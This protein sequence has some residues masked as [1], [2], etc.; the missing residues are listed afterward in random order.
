MFFRGQLILMCQFIESLYGCAYMSAYLCE[1]L[2]VY[3]KGLE[4]LEQRKVK[5][6]LGHHNV[7]HFHRLRA[8]HHL[9]GRRL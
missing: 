2:S 7:A 8:A 5:G 1:Y 9:M 6:Q 4:R 3:L